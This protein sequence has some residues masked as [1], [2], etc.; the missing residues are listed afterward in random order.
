MSLINKLIEAPPRSFNMELS[1]RNPSAVCVIGLGKLGLS[2]AA[3]LAK[4]G[5]TVYAVDKDE[6]IIE[7]V[8]SANS[9][10]PEPSLSDYLSDYAENLHLTTSINKGVTSSNM[11]FVFVNTPLDGGSHSLNQV[12]QVIY[13][14]GDSLI[15][16]DEYHSVVIRSTV[17]PRATTDTIQTWLESA[18]EK[19]VGTDVG[20]CYH[21]EF[22]AIG[23]IMD[24][25]QEPD[26][27]LI[28]ELDSY[29]GNRIEAVCQQLRQ[30]DA[31]ILRTDTVT[32]ELAKMA[33]NTFRTIK[34]SFAN[35]VG[36]IAH[37]V[38]ASADEIISSFNQDSNIES[39]YLVPGTRYGGPCYSRDNIAFNDLASSVGATGD[40]AMVADS[41]N[42]H[43]TRWVVDQVRSNTE[44][45]GDIGVLGISYKPNSYL[46]EDSQGKHLIEA[47]NAE[48]SIHWTNPWDIKDI[49]RLDVKSATQHSI[50]ENMLEVCDT[51]ILTVPWEEY[52]D[53]DLYD[54]H[55]ITLIDPWRMVESSGL[56]ESVQ[57]EPLAGDSEQ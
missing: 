24:S 38:G 25:L 53:A 46:L 36:E 15:N 37:E 7:T 13:S 33:N 3:V 31:K 22:S 29:T 10:Y 4:A 9:P 56:P 35:T 23:Q 43:H 16:V 12:K 34:I 51:A 50:P 6:Q 49:E 17:P 5:Y 11:T 55:D 2:F 20:L 19:T 47:L 21:P 57:Y 18:S 41:V 14:V 54:G 48:Y 32:A 40:L 1:E 28:G 27:F 39:N 42:D 52:F 26:F 44:S 30:N 8:R 45:S